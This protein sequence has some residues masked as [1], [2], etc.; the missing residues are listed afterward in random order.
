[1]FFIDP[2][3][4]P[5]LKLFLKTAVALAVVLIILLLSGIETWKTILLILDHDADIGFIDALPISLF[6]TFFIYGILVVVDAE[7]ILGRYV[8]VWSLLG[9]KTLLTMAIISHLL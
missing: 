3:Q 4:K 9:V 2:E 8:I 1:M 6:L 5:A 7:T